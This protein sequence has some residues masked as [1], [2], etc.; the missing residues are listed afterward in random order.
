[1]ADPSTSITSTKGGFDQAALYK[2]I[3]SGVVPY[4]EWSGRVRHG[5][6]LDLERIDNAIRAADTGIMWPLTDMSRE[7][8]ALNPKAQGIAAKTVLPLANADYDLTPAEGDGVNKAEAERIATFVRAAIAGIDNFDQARL[9]LGWGFFD[10]RAALETIFAPRNAKGETW[11][12]A[13]EWIVPQR[14]SYGP[15]RELI[16]VD[17]WGDW[18]QFVRRGPALQDVPGKFIGFTPRMYA[19]LQEREGLAPRFIYWLFFDRFVWRHRLK[20]TESFG[21]PWRIIEQQ[22]M[23]ALAG[24]KL[25]RNDGGEGGAPNDDGDA[26]DYTL[27]EAESV[28]QDGVM[29]LLPGQKATIEYPPAEVNEFFSQGSDKILERL[30]VLALHASIGSDANRANAIILK[31][32][33]DILYEFRAKLVS[34]AIQTG[35]VNVIVELNFGASALPYAPKFQIRTKPERD[36]DKE[37]DRVLKVAASVPVGAGVLYEASGYRPPNDGEEVITTIQLTPTDAAAI[38]R[39]DEARRKM[40]QKPVGGDVGEKWVIE[41]SATFSAFGT[42][43]GMATGEKVAEA[44]AAGEDAPPATSEPALPRGE[45]HSADAVGALRELLEDAD[46]DAQAQAVD[47]EADA[48]A[49]LTRWFAGARK[50][51]PSTVNG[52]PEV[53][54]ERGVREG[55]RLVEGWLDEMLDAADGS[56]PG[57]IYK[58]LQRVG[59]AVDIEPFARAL[60]R[61]VLHGLMLGGL[62]ADWEMENDAVIAPPQFTG[63]TFV[64][65]ASAG[66]ADFVTMP[67]GEALKAFTSRRILTKRSF[68]RL[69][70]AAKKKAFT[71]AGLQRKSMVAVAHDEL[72]KAIEA[73]DDLRSFSK[74]L[75]A[76]FED[77]GWKKLN[78]SHLETVFRNGVMSG[79]SDGRRAQM[80]Q[81]AVIAA[82]PYWQVLGVDDDR[83]RKP[84]KAAHKKVLA[85]SDPFWDRAPL[86]WG[87]NCRCRAVSRSAADL[88]RLGLPVTIG[89]QLRGLPDE[90]WDASGSLL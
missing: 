28:T 68:E 62:D 86:P 36:R 15:S 77:A 89:A 3:F 87:H 12:K 16:V 20:L 56:D 42:A 13:L 53:L 46:A 65:P 18:G 7:A 67:F 81:P 23:N 40:G 39:V 21:F 45:G 79:Y 54:V 8:L 44:G 76:R 58:R 34:A 24:L 48:Q 17:R 47:D 43:A 11:P 9:D 35:L 52:T 72:A 83:T 90:G 63:T 82:R 41:H 14:L 84:H 64:L 38:T 2:R 33:E 1:M 29:V 27:K 31:S 59:Q 22:I 10:G 70:G 85:A 71:V 74:A 19:D 26:L 55:A 49:G 6:A 69:L 60:E 30:E 57:R 61:R 50:V 88:K 80:T 73:G 75:N 5:A 32:P 51:Q 78:P 37:V 4:E 66:V 25:P